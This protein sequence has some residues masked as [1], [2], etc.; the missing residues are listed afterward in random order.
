MW[1]R[2]QEKASLW[3]ELSPDTFTVASTDNIDFLQSHAAVYCGDQSRSYHGTTIQVVQPVP[4]LKLFNSTFSTGQ[5]NEPSSSSQAL[6]LNQ[7]SALPNIQGLRGDLKSSGLATP[8]LS[9]DTCRPPQP[10]ASVGPTVNLC[11]RQSSSSST[12]SPHKHG[13]VG[14]K[15]QRTMQVSRVKLFGNTTHGGRTCNTPVPHRPGLHLEQFQELDSEM[16]SKGKLS[17]EVFAYFPLKQATGRFDLGEVLKPM[18]E[19]LLPTPAQLA[20]NEPSKVYYME[21]LDKNADSEETMA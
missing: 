20:D 1:L 14:P 8:S 9:V 2:Q 17:K 19:F 5:P 10:I 6:A 16:T 21:L 4:S 3:S 11:K 15:R 18:K 13:K 7:V 12:K